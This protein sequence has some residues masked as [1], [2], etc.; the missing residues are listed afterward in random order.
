MDGKVS[1][2][3]SHGVKLRLERFYDM[4]CS[5]NDNVAKIVVAVGSPG[6]ERMLLYARPK[7]LNPT[8]PWPFGLPKQ[9]KP[10]KRLRSYLPGP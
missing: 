8:V 3:A 2:K 9:G 10:P 5:N 7:V 4:V 1:F 6:G